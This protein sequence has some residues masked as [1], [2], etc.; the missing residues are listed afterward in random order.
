MMKRMKQ[1]DFCTSYRPKY[2]VKIAK[3]KYFNN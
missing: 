2:E 1:K 3:I